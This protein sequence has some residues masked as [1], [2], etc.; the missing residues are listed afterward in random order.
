MGTCLDGYTT[1]LLLGGCFP[2]QAQRETNSGRSSMLQLEGGRGRSDGSDWIRSTRQENRSGRGGVG[3]VPRSGMRMRLGRVCSG[4]G[5]FS[6]FAL[7]N[8]EVW[9]PRRGSFAISL[10]AWQ[11]AV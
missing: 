4:E 10:L 1:W 5:C 7:A 9:V 2:P 11:A 8:R 6:F 3:Q